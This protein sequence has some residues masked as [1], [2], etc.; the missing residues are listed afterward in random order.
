MGYFHPN[1]GKRSILH[2]V[3]LQDFPLDFITYQLSASTNPT[4]CALQKK[5]VNK[6]NRQSRAFPFFFWSF[7]W[8]VTARPQPNHR[9]LRWF[10]ATMGGDSGGRKS[11]PTSFD[12][13]AIRIQGLRVW[14]CCFPWKPFV[15]G[16]ASPWFSWVN[17]R[18][19]GNFV[20]WREGGCW[21]LEV[22][23]WCDLQE[24]LAVDILFKSPFGQQKTSED[25]P[26]QTICLHP[27]SLTARRW[28]MMVG[29]HLPL[30]LGPGNFSGALAVELPFFG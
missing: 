18:R 28:K 4:P 20:L 12:G 29:I 7:P 19:G 22:L 5:P 6:K 24:E 3:P 10:D 2:L 8:N 16:A 21:I 23:G 27:R 25:G 17:C 26:P 15:C 30:F 11:L 1:L 14:S 13:G 9:L